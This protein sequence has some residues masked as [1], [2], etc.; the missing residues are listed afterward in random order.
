MFIYMEINSLL[1]EKLTRNKCNVN[2]N[3]ITLQNIKTQT[4]KK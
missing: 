4:E 1:Y 3:T 2:L